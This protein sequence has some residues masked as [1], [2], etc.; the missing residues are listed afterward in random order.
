MAN[1]FEVDQKQALFGARFGKA[2]QTVG[3]S[4]AYRSNVATDQMLADNDARLEHLEDQVGL[5][6]DVTM[7]INAKVKEG[8]ALLE[9]FG[10]DMTKA[11]DMMS[12]TGKKLDRM[13]NKSGGKHMWYM[14]IFVVFVFILMYILTRR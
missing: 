7:G 10:I 5:L 6:K 3:N 2:P 9:K 1:R 4:D 12:K 13:I 14:M 8:N 11:S